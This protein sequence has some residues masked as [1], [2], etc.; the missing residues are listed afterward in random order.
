MGVMKYTGSAVRDYEMAKGETKIV[1]L[2][3]ATW[4]KLHKDVKNKLSEA[5]DS[6]EVGLPER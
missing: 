2:G 5:I 4:G 1:T 3:I 6:N